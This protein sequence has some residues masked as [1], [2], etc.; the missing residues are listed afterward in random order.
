MSRNAQWTAGVK[1]VDTILQNLAQL[2]DLSIVDE[3]DDPNLTFQK[4]A[5]DQ[6]H[7]DPF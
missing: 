3:Q 2:I 5:L 6:I 1:R 7:D 4:S